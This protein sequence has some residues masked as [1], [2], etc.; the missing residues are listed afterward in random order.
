MSD[1]TVIIDMHGLID[2]FTSKQKYKQC[3][4]A[5]NERFVVKLTM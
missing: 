4:A 5:G 3:L 1:T 2:S